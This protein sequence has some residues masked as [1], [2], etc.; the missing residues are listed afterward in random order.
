MMTTRL[1]AKTSR[2]T[3]S[4]PASGPA[5]QRRLGAGPGPTGGGMKSGPRPIGVG[6]G[7]A[8][9]AADEP[10][11]PHKSKT[12]RRRARGRWT[13]ISP[14]PL[15]P[16]RGF[17]PGSV[18]EQGFS[19]RRRT[20]LLAIIATMIS[21]ALQALYE[22]DLERA[23]QQLRPDEEL[24]AYEAAAFGRT[25]RLRELLDADPE[26]ARAWSPDGFT[27]LHLAIFGGSEEA[28]RL[29]VDRGAD[30]NV[31]ST[32]DIV[33]VRPLG[34]AAFVNRPDLE[35]ILLDAG[36]DPSLPREEPRT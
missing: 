24:P 11:P 21:Q 2:C 5:V 22:G 6:T 18:R 31:L 36:A 28:V 34:T 9:G 10:Q 29:L 17:R 3:R 27:S 25:A 13:T 32:S 4:G 23:R 15:H 12:T 14:L 1:L 16:L 19:A 26:V 7:R 20:D 30:V 8:S 35:Q 33:H